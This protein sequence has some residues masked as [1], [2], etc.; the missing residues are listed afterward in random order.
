MQP[1]LIN[2][3]LNKGGKQNG[4]N[5]PWREVL[6]EK[7]DSTFVDSVIACNRIRVGIK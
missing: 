2:R 4:G 3:Q 7:G 1:K 6:T 5:V